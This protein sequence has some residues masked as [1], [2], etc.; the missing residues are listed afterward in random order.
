MPPLR[1]G[2][3]DPDSSI[4]QLIDYRDCRWCCDADPIRLQQ[5]VRTARRGRVGDAGPEPPDGGGAEH[6]PVGD[7]AAA[8]GG[9]EGAE[10]AEVRWPPSSASCRF[11]DHLGSVVH[12]N[13]SAAEK[14]P[15]PPSF[16]GRSLT[17]EV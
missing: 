15:S 2:H 14:I 11:I 10:H 13:K 16:T 9:G 3:T 1:R 6:H 12:E 4:K 8:E 7:G 17:S 5:D